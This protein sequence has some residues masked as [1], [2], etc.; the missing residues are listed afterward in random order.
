MLSWGAD[1]GGK[2]EMRNEKKKA[3]CVCAC[4]YLHVSRDSRVL[5]VLAYAKVCKCSTDGETSRGLLS[6]RKRREVVIA[7]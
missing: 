5:C 7:F 3:V 2:L 4:K 6:N 1:R